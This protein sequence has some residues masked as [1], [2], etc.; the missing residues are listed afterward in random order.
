MSEDLPQDA[1]R[2]ER[3]D[4]AA[5][6]YLEAVERG[7]RPDRQAWLSRFPDLACELGEFIDNEG[8][9]DRWAA[10]EKELSI[11]LS[12]P[13]APPTLPASELSA[14]PCRP[15]NYEL[16]GEIAR[17]GMGIVFRARQLNPRRIVALKMI[18]AGPHA[19]PSELYRFRMETEAAAS[20]DHPNIM[21]IY[22]VGDSAGRP[23]FSMKL[24]EGGTLVEQLPRFAGDGRAAAKLLVKIAR[25]VHHAHQRGILHRDLKPANILLDAAGEPCVA[26]FG[27]C[28]RVE[29]E[30]GMTQPGAIVGTPSYMS[31]EQAAG[32]KDLT[33]ATD[34]YS[35]GAIL[36]TLLT[37]RPPF[38]GDTPLETMRGV[39]EQEPSR[40]RLLR[41]AVDRD[42]ETICLKC[43][44]KLPT[45]RYGSAEALADDLQRWLSGEPIVARRSSI[46][47]RTWKRTRRNPAA[48]ALIAVSSLALVLLIAFGVATQ[49]QR[50]RDA[51]EELARLANVAKIGQEARQHVAQAEQCLRSGDAQNARALAIR[52]SE[53]CRALPQLGDLATQAQQLLVAAERHLKQEQARAKAAASVRQFLAHRDD[54][55][56]HASVNGPAASAVAAEQSGAAALAAVGLSAEGEGSPR[57]DPDFSPSERDAVRAGAYEVLLLLADLEARRQ[58][59]NF[60]KALQLS[61]RALDFGSATHAL[62]VRR[63]RYLEQLGRPGESARE[64][65]AAAALPSTSALDH[66][67]RGEEAWRGGDLSLATAELRHAL[68][69]QPGH[70]WARVYLA[71]CLQVTSPRESETH[72]TTVLHLRPD[73]EYAHLLR[74]TAYT[75]LGEFA[76]AEQDYARAIQRPQLRFVGLVNRGESR[77]RQGQ[78]QRA[79]SDFLQALALL[80]QA[81]PPTLALARIYELQG[82]LD[83]AKD[84]LD[85]SLAASD[86]TPPIEAAILLYRARTA[87]DPAAAMTDV[88]RS[89]QRHPYAEAYALRADLRLRAGPLAAPDYQAIVLDCELALKSAAYAEPTYLVSQTHYRRALALNQLGRYE[90]AAQSL[91]QYLASG[92]QPSAEIHRLLGLI[93][94]ERT[95]FPEALGELSKALA[96]APGDAGVLAERG[97]AYLAMGAL[98]LALD[99]FQQALA[100]DAQNVR[101]LAGRGLIRA[102]QRNAAGA[103]ADAELACRLGPPTQ[104]I[105]WLAA[106]TYAICFAHLEARGRMV[107]VPEGDA[108]FRYRDRAVGLLDRA[109]ALTPENQRAGFWHEVIQGDSW[110][111]LLEQHPRYREL[112]KQFQRPGG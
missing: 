46:W 95:D 41:P 78:L 10:A 94:L 65:E 57:L 22:E 4:A 109:L 61:T 96:L 8:Q 15:P 40:P 75:R 6:A 81:V 105:T 89:I 23:F 88:E 49:N 98:R 48:T 91:E 85:Q 79:E 34:V 77:L 103:E 112:Q 93:Q 26:D 9:W 2:E 84:K 92:G 70:V 47:E 106:R 13:E 52:A 21:P 7:E 66:F 14:P 97:S 31:P 60:E 37:D 72:L 74:G 35:L 86:L 56:Y 17:G 25:A 80:P 27:L 1:E 59:P 5:A 90:E 45:A 50:L 16:L 99:D 39:L 42:L 51:R 64:F 30:S 43:L 101:A 68:R 104:R 29:V 44:E 36:Y 18:L 73:L 87:R 110:L 67:F 62:H 3:L 12:A 55:L 111:Q 54:V 69:Q 71:A 19:L 32:R 38:R 11:E 24:M 83:E 76:E 100:L 102:V 20:L 63:G 53:Q 82:R 108:K 33:T 28:R 107:S 58:P